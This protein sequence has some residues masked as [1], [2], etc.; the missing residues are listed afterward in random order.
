M[1]GLPKSMYSPGSPYTMSCP[2]VRRRFVPITESMARSTSSPS[3]CASS[4]R[5]L[6]YALVDPAA[7]ELVLMRVQE[8]LLQRDEH[9]RGTLL[10]ALEHVPEAPVLRVEAG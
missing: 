1:Y 4:A 10:V 6:R 8:V 7:A 2:Y 9:P 5:C 3:L